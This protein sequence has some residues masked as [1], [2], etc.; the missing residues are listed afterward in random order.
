LQIDTGS[1]DIW[2]Q[3]PY[4]RLCQSR[5]DPCAASGTYDNTSSSSYAYVNSDFQIQY[6]DGTEAVGDYATETF[7]IGGNN[8]IPVYM[9]VDR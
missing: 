1:S 2:V 8:M 5:G 3:V 6:A 4:S 9:I 7:N